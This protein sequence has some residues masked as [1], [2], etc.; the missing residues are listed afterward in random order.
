MGIPNVGICCC[1]GDRKQ[2]R[3]RIP[4]WPGRRLRRRFQHA[5]EA[6]S[7]SGRHRTGTSDSANNGSGNGSGNGSRRRTTHGRRAP[8]GIGAVVAGQTT[9]VERPA[10]GT[11]GHATPNVDGGG[12][13]PLAAATCVRARG[14]GLL[15]RAPNRATAQ[16]RRR[17]P[18]RIAF[19]LVRRRR[20]PSRRSRARFLLKRRKRRAPE[21]GAAARAR[22]R[23]RT[24]T[25]PSV[26]R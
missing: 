5:P 13:P 21:A 24:F 8:A 12:P 1:V 15:E 3:R 4:K 11:L 18:W 7:S 6:Q 16:L 22:M 17:C 23:C 9:T 14:G 26:V 20:P 19:Q 2:T 10:L 25:P